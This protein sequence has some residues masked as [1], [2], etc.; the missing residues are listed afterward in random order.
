[1]RLSKSNLQR[2]F[3]PVIFQGACWTLSG[4][5]TCDSLT[6]K[7]INGNRISQIA[8]LKFSNVIIEL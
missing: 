6:F 4:Q 8:E 2:D 1:M 5:E 3:I 7:K